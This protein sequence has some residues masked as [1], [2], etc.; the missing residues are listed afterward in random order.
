MSAS[1]KGSNPMTHAFVLNAKVTADNAGTCSRCGSNE[2]RNWAVHGGQSARQDCGRCGHTLCFSIWYGQKF[3]A[4]GAQ[5][6]KTQKPAKAKS[7]G[8]PTCQKNRPNGVKRQPPHVL[9]LLLPRCP[10]CGSVEHKVLRSMP[11]IGDQRRR[12][13]ECK[14]CGARLVVIV[15]A[16]PRGT[17]Q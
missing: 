15:T 5:Y 7:S 9:R 4:D 12:Y 3:H 14:Q 8:R 17:S 10:G 16:P 11:R 2:R 6:M 13:V 1:S